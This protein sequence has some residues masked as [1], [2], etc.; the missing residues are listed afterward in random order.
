MVTQ[1]KINNFLSLKSLALIG[2]SRN[3]KKFGNAIYKEFKL[4]NYT[5][6]PVNPY[7]DKYENDTCYPDLKSLPSRPEG[8]IIVTNREKSLGIVKDAHASGINN[9]WITQMS[10]TKDTI[11]YCEKNNIN[12]IYKQCPLMFLEPVQTFH[13]FHKFI[14]K[15]FGRLPK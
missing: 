5:V 2:V 14:K 10:E 11:E 12:V 7:L 9:I 1:N 3:A 13:K 4:K 15:I 6:Y 8:L